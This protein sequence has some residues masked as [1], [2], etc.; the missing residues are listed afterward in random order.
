[1]GSNSETLHYLDASESSLT[2]GYTPILVLNVSE[3]DFLL[4]VLLQ[5]GAFLDGPIRYQVQGKV[6]LRSGLHYCHL[7]DAVPL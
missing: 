1:M 6:R 4:P 2:S 3:L 7:H 5:Q